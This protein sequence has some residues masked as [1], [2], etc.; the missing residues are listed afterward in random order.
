MISYYLQWNPNPYILDGVL[1]FHLHWY[2]VLFV[3]GFALAYYFAQKI[4]KEL[5]LPAAMLDN[6]LLLSLF[7]SILFA[8]IFH[9]LFY[10][11]ELYANNPS[12]ILK[13][14][15]GGLASHGGGF[16]LMVALYIWTKYYKQKTYWIILDIMAIV[17]PL[18][19][20]FIRI[21]NFV[22]SEILGKVSDLPWA[23]V[24]L[25]E[26]NPIPRHPAQLYESLAYFAIFLIQYFTYKKVGFPAKAYYLF[27]FLFYIFSVRFIIEFVKEKQEN[28]SID[29]GLNMG[30]ILSIPFIVVGLIGI[31]GPMFTKKQLQ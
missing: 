28:I 25:Q 18:A 29:L 5:E 22:N 20:A 11:F 2:G 26:E 31:L 9:V 13:I 14:W 10:D 6:L 3:T 17:T 7:F 12:H 23:V 21:G 27:R 15:E 8:R 16:G 19:G 1:P 24:F 30:A 4:Y